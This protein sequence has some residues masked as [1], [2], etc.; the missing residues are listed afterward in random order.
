[1]KRNTAPERWA[2]AVYAIVRDARGRVLLLQRSQSTKHFPGY[3]ELPGGKPVPGNT[4]DAT[5]VIEVFEE[6]GLH[7]TPTGVAGAADG[8]VPGIRVAMLVLETR[9]RS[10][11]VSLS[12]EHDD[13]RWVP[14]DQVF[15]LKLRPRFDQFFAGYAA[16]CSHKAAK[17]PL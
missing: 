8:S 7:V 10:T 15:S 17:R 1:M 12:D 14:P 9:T 2:L 5:A 16:R 6:T 4:F 13:F 11:K 3:W